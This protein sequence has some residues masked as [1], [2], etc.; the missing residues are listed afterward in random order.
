MIEMADIPEPDRLED[1]P[2]PRHTLALF[3]QA[4]AEAGFLA[5]WNSER[6]HHAWLVTG[7]RGV[8]KATLAWRIAR[9]LLSQSTTD[10]GAGLFGETAPPDSLDLAKDHPVARRVAALS[11]PR[12]YLCR[13]PWNE[14]TE[15]LSQAITV[16]E[17]RRLKSFFNL[18]AADGGWRVAIVD[19][20]DEMNTAAANALLKILEE[21]PEKTV[22]LLVSHRPMALLPTIRSRC[23]TLNC[24][25]LGPEDMAAALSGAGQADIGDQ[26]ALAA[27]ADGSVGE[28]VRLLSGG[29]LDLYRD[30]LAIAAATPRMPRP[31]IIRLADSCAGR[32]AEARFDLAVRLTR[33]LLHRLALTGAR[34]APDLAAGPGEAEVLRRLS[35]GAA[36]ARHWAALAETLTA[37]IAHG[38]AVNLDPA[39]LILDMWLKIDQA[40]GAVRTA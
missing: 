10:Q 19:S 30:M 29:G 17:V 18:S 4:S 33:T 14:K 21:P 20:A 24:A 16:E 39:S 7:P 28:A 22:I 6:L 23:R 2:H 37:R 26:A 27:L 31:D 40:A 25:A 12:L 36:A 38:R 32:A 5:A 13:R 35:P 3:G 1:A 15:R 34:G 11:E 9:F 8:G